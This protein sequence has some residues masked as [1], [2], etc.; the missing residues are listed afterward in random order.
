MTYDVCVCIYNIY[1][2]YLIYYG[3]IYMHIFMCMY[4]YIYIYI[5]MCIYV[6]EYS[7]NKLPIFSLRFVC[8][9]R[10]ALKHS[11]EV[12]FSLIIS[13]FSRAVYS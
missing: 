7:G 8:L 4:I 5:C 11:L 10:V 13:G 1:T 6:Y 3:Y 2:S 9:W 12:E